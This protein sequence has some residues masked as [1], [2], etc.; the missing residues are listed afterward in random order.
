MKKYRNILLVVA[1]LSGSCP[2]LAQTPATGMG[3]AC[4]FVLE[5]GRIIGG[6]GSESG[7]R[8]MDPVVF[9]FDGD[10]IDDVVFGAPGFTPNGMNY[11]GSL[12]VILGRKDF[13]FH[14]L[15]DMTYWSQFDYRFDG[16]THGAQ[17]GMTLYTGDF[18][19]DGK[20]DLAAAA[21][22]QFGT[23]YVFYGGKSRARGVHPVD[24]EKNGAD[25]AFVG[26]EL[27]SHFGI[28]GC[29]GDFNHD[30][31]DDLALSSISSHAA[32]GMNSSLVTIIPMRSRWEK[33]SYSMAS[34]LNGKT[35]MSRPLSGHARAV[36]SCAAADFNDDGIVDIALGM[37]LD[38]HQKQ[39]AVG[40]VSIIYQPYRYNGTTIDLGNFDPKYGVRIS[41][42]QA[43]AQF[44]Y[45]LAA[46]D[47][48]GDERADLIVSAPNRLISGRDP[49][50]AVYVIDANQFP[51]K[52]GEQPD[53][54]IR[55]KGTGG[56]F[57]QRIW[58]ADVNGDRRKDIVVSASRAGVLHS[59]SVSIWLGGPHFVES[60]AQNLR[61]DFAIAGGDFMGFGIGAAFGDINGDGKPDAVF[62][63][64]SDPLQ[65]H[66][67]GAYAV[68]SDIPSLGQ[69]TELGDNFM[70]ITAPTLG[71]GLAPKTASVKLG[72]VDYDVWFSP[73]GM[74]GRSVLCLT[75]SGRVVNDA[76]SLIDENAC[77]YRIVGPQDYP[78]ADFDFTPTPT[79]RPQI[80]ISVPS[81]PVKK[82]KGFVAAIALPDEMPKTLVL[83]LNEKTLR[84]EA[85]TFLLSGESDAELGAKIEWIDMDGDGID[86]LII[87]APKRMIDADTSGSV[88]IVKGSASTKNGFRELV[89]KD[90]V[91]YDGFL[92]EQI[93]S[94]WRVVDFDIDGKPDLALVSSKSTNAAGEFYAVAYVL[95][96]PAYR[97][98]KE[99]SVRAPEIAALQIQAAQPK[100]EFKLVPQKVDLNGDGSGELLI[101][102]PNHRIGVQKQGILYAVF[103]SKERSGGILDLQNVAPN[104]TLSAGRNERI[105][106]IRFVSV[107]GKLQMIL[108]SSDFT[109]SVN[110]TIRALAMPE[111]APFSGD[112]AVP[113]LEKM[114][115]DARF[116]QRVQ[117]IASDTPDAQLW[118]VYP[119]DGNFMTRQGIIQK[120]RSWNAAKKQKAPSK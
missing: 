66:A 20:T 6:Q 10:G 49:E 7:A 89:S 64:T 71:G 115:C 15:R 16:H 98:P 84:S 69:T 113:E 62:R 55:I 37:P 120:V 73:M 53:D 97:T 80:T 30:G 57:G 22:G 83:N 50:G 13:S 59:G 85:R 41:G 23:V 70:T 72:D 35:V 17:L 99:Y 12:F 111:G 65:R 54:I 25:I 79:M 44:G 102:S 46:G 67:T 114:A 38:S 75:R 39:S 68:M 77:D 95:F 1:L 47:V 119:D 42:N 19:G 5:Q 27:G 11:S 109:S 34:K 100:T 81:M 31:I 108:A 61:P 29:V 43:N 48:T 32:Y 116:P 14:S 2:V 87:G 101:L 21:P 112:W 40:S 45:A 3:D 36:H 86:D 117:L 88:F 58:L 96:S 105:D 107:A 28:T 104:F 26:G 74:Q 118:F 18:N 24:D 78:I 56:R 8:L 93:G 4:G 63:L 106:D 103:A 33:K 52:S 82:S 91:S 76:V 60:V 51:K 92:N 9:D 90:V 110:T 94:D